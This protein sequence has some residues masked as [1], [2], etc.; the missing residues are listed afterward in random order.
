MSGKRA[1]ASTFAL[2][3]NVSVT[4][5]QLPDGVAYRFRHRRL[6]LLGQLVVTAQGRIRRRSAVRWPATP[7]TP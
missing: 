7:M 6:G 3:P 1:S 2:P 5:Q 4:R